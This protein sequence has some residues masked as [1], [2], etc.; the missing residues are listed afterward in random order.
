MVTKVSYG[1]EIIYGNNSFLWIQKY[2]MDTRVDYGSKSIARIHEYLM[3]TK[4]FNEYKS[5]LRT[6]SI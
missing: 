1:Y 6:L 2:I 5:I 3:D 4:V